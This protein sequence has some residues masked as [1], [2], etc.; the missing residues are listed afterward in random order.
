MSVGVAIS[1]LLARGDDISDLVPTNI[2][3]KNKPYN[4]C[5]R[6]IDDIS[7]GN[8]INFVTERR[9]AAIGKAFPGVVAHAAI[10]FPRQIGVVV[11][12]KAIH[13]SV[14]DDAFRTVDHWLLDCNNLNAAIPQ[15]LLGNRQRIAVSTHAVNSVN[16]QHFKQ[17]VFR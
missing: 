2:S 1:T 12:G 15:L 16:Q 4:F 8:W 3:V 11:F 7:F 9:F 10:D 6:F 17:M 13:Q 5:L 14:E